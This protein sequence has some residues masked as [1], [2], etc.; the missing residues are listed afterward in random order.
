MMRTATTKRD[1]KL[2]AAAIARWENEGG[3]SAQAPEQDKIG[4]IWERRSMSVNDDDQED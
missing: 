3:T 2:H 1:L 4:K